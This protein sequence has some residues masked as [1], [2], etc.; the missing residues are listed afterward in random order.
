MQPKD[1]ETM[2]LIG[3]RLALQQCRHTTSYKSLLHKN[4][5]RTVRVFAILRVGS[6]NELFGIFFGRK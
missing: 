3:Q 1:P 5:S 6:Q 4:H 2:P